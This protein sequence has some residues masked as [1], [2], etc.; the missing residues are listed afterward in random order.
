MQGIIQKSRICQ[1]KTDSRRA[2]RGWGEGGGVVVK[3]ISGKTRKGKVYQKLIQLS[4]H[5]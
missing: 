4:Y 2:R 1:E 5:N 3:S